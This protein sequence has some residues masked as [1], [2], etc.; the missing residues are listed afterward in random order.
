MVTFRALAL[1]QSDRR[2]ALR[3]SSSSE[4][5]KKLGDNGHQTKCPKAEKSKQ[6]FPN[7]ESKNG[8]NNQM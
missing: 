6:K 4:R 1:H 8:K 5:R 2:K 3:Q 7:I